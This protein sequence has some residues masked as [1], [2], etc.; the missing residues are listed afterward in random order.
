MEDKTNIQKLKGLALGGYG[1]TTEDLSEDVKK[2][3]KNI[4]EVQLQGEDL[5]ADY[6]K[7]LIRGD[8]KILVFIGCD[9]YFTMAIFE[10]NSNNQNKNLNS[11]SFPMKD[12]IK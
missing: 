9:E 1:F 6:S 2:Y 10:D 8:G 12:L 4:D 11:T 3:I 5:Y 7:I